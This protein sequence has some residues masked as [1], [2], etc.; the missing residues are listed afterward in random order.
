MTTDLT[1]HIEAI[2]TFALGNPN[3]THSTRS[4]WRYGTNGSVAV[5]VTGAKAGIWYDH[6]AKEGGGPWELLLRKLA[7]KDIP[8]WLA[9]NLGVHLERAAGGHI[10]AVYPYYD[11][12]GRLLFEVCRLAPKRFRQRRPSGE[13]GIQGVRRVLYRLPELI[14][15]P[16]DALVYIPEG[17]KDCDRL[18]TLWGLVATCNPMGAGK[19]RSEYAAFLRGRH[20]VVI[21]DNDEVGHQHAVEIATSLAAV[22]ASVRVLH[23]QNLPEKGDISDWIVA[24]G[25]QSDLAELAEDTPLFQTGSPDADARAASGAAADGAQDDHGVGAMS[26]HS[27]GKALLENSAYL[28]ARAVVWLWA[29]WLAFGK[30]HLLAGTKTTGKSTLAINLMAI[31]TVG[32]TWP[33]GTQA[34]LGDVIFWTGEDDI[35]DTILPRFDAAGGDRKRFHILRRIELPNGKTVPFDPSIDLTALMEAARELPE[36]KMVTIEPVV[37]V[38]PSDADSHKNTETRRGLQPLVDFAELLKIVLLGITHFT[39]GSS[40]Q[41]P[42]ER[43]TGSLAFTAIARIVLGAWVDPETGDRRLVRI[44]S[45]IGRGGGGYEYELH[46]APLPDQDF[47]ALHLRWGAELKGSAAELLKPT[48]PDKSESALDEAVA[49]LREFLGKGAKP[50]DDVVTA[51]RAH[52]HAW[53]TVRRAQKELGIK[54]RPPGE[55]RKEWFWELPEATSKPPGFTPD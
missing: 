10:V 2:A 54:P 35:E 42:I 21:A 22:A 40:D 48:K 34:P 8:D 51:A 38:I 12:S 43:V 16:K 32:G 6:E 18:A 15:A 28:L 9:R 27:R 33:D 29:G 53:A 14:A 41:D 5:E 45:N 23:L 26:G 46:E 19:W 7:D 11:E 25:T 3:P 52:G 20:C 13:W 24:G 1:R 31:V 30:F 47:A 36:L 50:S 4:Q 55:G 39:K 44:A 49:F 37:M 17:E